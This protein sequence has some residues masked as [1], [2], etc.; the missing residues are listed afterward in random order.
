MFRSLVGSLIAFAA[1]CATLPCL[2]GTA[3]AVSKPI[4][5]GTN[6]TGLPSVPAVTVDSTGTLYAVWDDQP[7][8]TH[9]TFCKVPV[10][11]TGC[12]PV[13]LAVPDP[14]RAQFFDPPSVLVAGTV[15]RIFEEVDGAPDQHRDG[16]D[17]WISTDGGATFSMFPNSLSWTGVGDTAGAGPMPVVPLFGDSVGI[18]EISA[19]SNPLFQAN[20]LTSPTD[21]SA[22]TLPTPFATLPASYTVGN[23]GGEFAS[24]LT[25]TTGVLGVFELLE[26]GPCPSTS[27]LVFS[28]ATVNASTTNAALNASS[29]WSPLAA[30][31]C[32]AEYPAVR[33]GQ[34]GLGV[35]YPDD[36][37][38]AGVTQYRKFT[39][40]GTFSSSVT[41][42]GGTALQPSLSQ[43]GAGGIYATWLTNGTGLRLAWSGD[44]GLGW[45]G[46]NTLFK[47]TTSVSLDSVASAVDASGQGWAVYA[48]NGT[49]YAQPF[50]AADSYVTPQ[51]RNLR[52][53][54]SSFA[55]SATID[56][57]DTEAAKTTF[58]VVELVKAGKVTHRVTIGTFTHADLNGPG[59][60][61]FPATVGGHALAKGRYELEATPTLGSFT[62]KTATARF[63]VT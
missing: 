49:E 36:T 51:D 9:L 39:A 2:T 46:D 45:D 20:S 15:V 42:A 4:A 16:F 22:A 25:G 10:G 26:T 54:P 61:P 62:G 19:V 38:L 31:Q 53:K 40:P 12:A 23:L 21:Y 58:T 50:T 41:V 32:N 8:D 60:L 6:T 7:A 24:Q 14:A 34:S 47:E 29:A 33:G 28:W 27:G 3:W 52:V 59:S 5:I 57:A 13:Q 17:E 44:G 37:N 56:Y 30:V 1:A 55:S 48:S 63:T 35:L 18:G 43:D 11:A